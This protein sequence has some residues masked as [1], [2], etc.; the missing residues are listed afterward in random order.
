MKA[1]YL[2]RDRVG[3]ITHANGHLTRV[4]NVSYAQFERMVQKLDDVQ[5]RD[6]A[7]A[8]QTYTR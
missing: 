1:E 5:I 7:S 2:E 6:G 4:A 8:A 3:V